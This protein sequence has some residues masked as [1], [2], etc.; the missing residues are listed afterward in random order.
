MFFNDIHSTI[1]KFSSRKGARFLFD[2][3]P[4]HGKKGNE[5]QIFNE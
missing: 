2:G 3:I 4:I 5:V 1:G